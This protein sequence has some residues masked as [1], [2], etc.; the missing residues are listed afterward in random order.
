MF[1]N[2]KLL[3]LDEATSAL[4]GGT[5]AGIS[6]SIESLRESTTV[7]LI[8]HRLST[9]LNSDLVVYMK[10]GA[11]LASGTFD[12]VRR[13]VPEFNDQASQAGL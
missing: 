9:I 13:E 3:V 8:A 5:Q 2:P 12:H 11:I 4:D 7:V 6:E 1:T 10:D